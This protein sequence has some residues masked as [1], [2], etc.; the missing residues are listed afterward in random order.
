MQPDTNA[1]PETAAAPRPGWRAQLWWPLLALLCMFILKHGEALAPKHVPGGE[2]DAFAAVLGS[3]TPPIVLLWVVFAAIFMRPPRTVMIGLSSFAA[4][5]VSVVAASQLAVMHRRVD[6]MTQYATWD[7]NRIAQIAKADGHGEPGAGTGP[8]SAYSVPAS[9]KLG[10]AMGAM[11]DMEVKE[12]NQTRVM[13]QQYVQKI[14]AMGWSKIF[15]VER[16]GSDT[17]LAQSKR[18]VQQA[19]E[20]VHEYRGRSEQ[21]FDSTQS[22]AETI[23]Q[24][25]DMDAAQRT[26]FLA[27]LH[28]GTI[29]AK[30]TMSNYWDFQQDMVAQTGKVFDTLGTS[31]GWRIDGKHI[32]YTDPATRNAVVSALDAIKD[33][34]TR[35]HQLLA[36]VRSGQLSRSRHLRNRGG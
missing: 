1:T 19:S 8:A 28:D 16:I 5:S 10:G 6:A 33:D 3:S 34:V 26:A 23:A 30:K 17:N 35:E 12:A 4:I 11:Q 20:L 18:L 36:R 25:M 24:R 15:S 22:Q 27:G 21:I 13:A 7:A 32:V 31:K 14:K 9:Q 2:A 29:D